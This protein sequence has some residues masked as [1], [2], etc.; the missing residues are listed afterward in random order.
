MEFV[1]NI[2][3]SIMTIALGGTIVFFLIIL[4]GIKDECERGKNERKNK[5]IR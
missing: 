5:R 2:I 3:V 1:I 4:N